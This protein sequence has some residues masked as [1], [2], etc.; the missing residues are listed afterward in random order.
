[1][2][3][4]NQKIKSF[5]ASIIVFSILFSSF[6]FKAK[7]KDLPPFEELSLGSSVF[8]FRG[9]TKKPRIQEL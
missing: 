2:Y 6:V 7:A 3:L 8:I 9:S 1:M 4:E 5:F